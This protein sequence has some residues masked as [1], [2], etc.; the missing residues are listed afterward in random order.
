MASGGVVLRRRVGIGAFRLRG[1]GLTAEDGL[2]ISSGDFG[3]EDG[4]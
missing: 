2:K 3:E 4:R 1:T